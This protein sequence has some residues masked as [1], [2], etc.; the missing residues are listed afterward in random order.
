MWGIPGVFKRWDP[1]L[2]KPGG[3]AGMKWVVDRFSSK[4]MCR[5]LWHL[6]YKRNSRHWHHTTNDFTWDVIWWTRQS[7]IRISYGSMVWPE[8]IVRSMGGYQ[9]TEATL[10]TFCECFKITKKSWHTEQNK[11]RRVI[12]KLVDQMF[13]ECGYTAGQLNVSMWIMKH[14]CCSLSEREWAA[15]AVEIWNTISSIH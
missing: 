13:F 7:Q 14:N 15:K 1:L 4:L 8:C 11:S 3:V 6:W 10:T 5:S 12:S 2:D 9:W